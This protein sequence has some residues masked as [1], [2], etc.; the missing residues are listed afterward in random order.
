LNLNITQLGLGILIA[1]VIASLA[2][3]FK[4]LSK[5]GSLAA[6]LLGSVVFGLGGLTW[7]IVLM[8]FFLTSSGLS[9]IFK[10]RKAAAEEIYAKGSV[11]DYRQV[12]ANG[13]AAGLFVILSLFIPQ[14]PVPWLGFCAALAAANADTWATELGSLSKRD[15]VLISTLKPVECG[16]SGGVSFFGLAAS[17]LGAFVIAGAGILFAPVGLTIE[18]WLFFLAVALGG[19]AGS[20]ADSWIGATLQAI[21]F[22]PQCT[23]E[24]EKH[25]R[26]GCGTETQLLR[27]RHWMTNDLVNL[28]CTLKGAGAAIV[29]VALLQLIP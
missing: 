21:Y 11:R 17:L 4:L 19:F 9:Y 2:F 10:S 26:H 28:L 22:C 12:L 18:P 27:G 13:G 6:F 20:L 5:S 1:V 16:T 3:K 15:P 8:V 23:R 29:I 25:P 24:T 7:S 14:S